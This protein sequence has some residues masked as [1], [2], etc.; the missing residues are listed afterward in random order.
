ME[1]LTRGLASQK[2]VTLIEILAS[3]VILSIIVISL[4]SFFA[5]SSLANTN[6]KKMQ[7]ATY[8]AVKA[9]EEVNNTISTT[10]QPSDLNLL[11]LSGYSKVTGT[12]ST[13]EKSPNPA[14]YFVR[15]VLV[16]KTSPMISIKVK[17]YQDSSMSKLEAQ[18]E[19]LVSWKQQ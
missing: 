13:F 8:I 1:K 5:Q 3:I 15:V 19:M 12:T 11:S 7:S 9:M 16:P 18:M 10:V 2:G 4:M 17:V 14:G 6:T